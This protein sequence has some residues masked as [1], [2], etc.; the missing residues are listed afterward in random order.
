MPNPKKPFV[1]QAFIKP[2]TIES[3]TFQVRLANSVLKGGNSLVVAPTALGKTIV[4]ALV[5][6]NIL[7]KKPGKKILFLAPTKPLCEQH[8][9]TMKKLMKL[10]PESIVMLTGSIV[11]KKRAEQWN[12]A[13]IVVATPQTIGN[14]A[15][16]ARI[17][18][19]NVSLIVFD[20]AHRAVG[21]YAYVYI[22]KKFM[23]KNPKGLVLGLTA[24]P[25]GREEHIKEV[26]KNLGTK[27]I[28][29]KALEDEDVLQYSH[30]INVEW[31][32]VELPPEFKK[33]RALIEHFME[34]KA[35]LIHKF[36]LSK[37]S[38]LKAFGKARLITMQNTVRRRIASSGGK[39]PSLFSAASAIASM[40]KASHAHTLLETQGVNALHS[41]L[42]REKNKKGKVSRATS[43]FLAN[44]GIV[45]AAELASKLS[46]KGIIHPKFEVLAKILQQQFELKPESSAIVFNHY[47]DSIKRLTQELNKI[48]G[49]R[50]ERFVGQASKGEEKGMTQKEQAE[51]IEELKDGKLNCLVASSVH[52]EEFIIV[53]NNVENRL[54]IKKIGEFV[55][56]FVPSKTSK[57]KI[58]KIKGYS[59]LS[60]NGTKTDFLPITH[61]HKHLR[62]S[63]AVET[64]FAS[65]FR[66]KI[67]EDHSLFTFDGNSKLVPSQPKQNMFAKVCLSAPNIEK[68]ET[69]DLAKQLYRKLPTTNRK[70]VYCTISGLNQP[71]IRILSSNRKFLESISKKTLNMETTS[72]KAHLDRKTVIVVRN[73]LEA[74]SFISTK[75]SG[76]N[77]LVSITQ[78]GK[79]YLA[80]LEWLFENTRYYKGKYRLSL[81]SVAES[82]LDLKK[83][84]DI[85]IEASYGKIKLPRFLEVKPALAEMLGLYV[86]EGSA[87]NTSRTAGIHLAARKKEMQKRMAISVREGLGIKPSMTWRGVDIHS[88]LAHYLIKYVFR[89]GIGAYN[90]EV[91][92][93]VFTLPTEHK[94]KFLEG[95]TRG[96]GHI[97]E[98]RIVLT[99]VSKKLVTGL[100]F[101]LRQLGIK[102][103]TLQKSAHRSTFDV[104][105][106]ESV[107]FQKI[108]VKG[109][110]CYYDL[111]PIAYSNKRKFAEAK[112]IFCSANNGQK[113]RKISKL[114]EPTCFDYIKKITPIKKQPKFVYDLSVKKT[115]LFVGG[116]GLI[117]LHNSVAEEGLD[118]PSVD[119]VVFYEPVPSEIRLIQRRGR[120]GRLAA[121]KAVILMARNTRDEVYY[122]TSV[123]KEKKMH[124]IL[125]KMKGQT[126]EETYKKKRQEKQTT[127]HSFQDQSDKIVVYVDTR[128][129]ES[130]V[131]SQ[132]KEMGCSVVEKQLG[133]GDYVPGKE[134]AVERKTVSD[135]LSSIVDGR[136]GKQLINMTESYERPL[137]IVEGDK[138]EL[139]ESRNIHKNAIIGMLT[140]IALNYG[141]PILFTENA[142]ETADY[143]YVIAKREQLGKGSDV[144]LRIG[145]KG[146]SL[147]EQQR[148]LVE[149]LPLVG[150][151]MS[152]K[153]LQKFGSVKGIVNAKSKELQEIENMG[154]KKAKLI[155]QVLLKEYEGE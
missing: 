63:K 99:T 78:K 114:T 138:E 13:K 26:C 137:V 133:V 7:E 102:K 132:L 21:E 39:N 112:N 119:L 17:S 73:R 79:K 120:T 116:Q 92:A 52:P 110:K 72:E 40:M 54:E 105:I 15:R 91:P 85:F 100:I 107:P 109:N 75:N 127:L 67:T 96:D 47:R 124:K 8:Q 64:V 61:V 5:M 139:F 56:S 9:K 129:K 12:N 153:L 65:G 136:L 87:R 66:T 69:L 44:M 142:K 83:F 45:Q 140:S 37:S 101:L 33:I 31:K 103:I 118:I 25:G 1:K 152:K 29:I 3:R 147:E 22:A 53:Q 131:A 27:N 84:C 97:T 42:E 141:M 58:A 155:R 11:Y 93:I 49:L 111:V 23:K 16:H 4:A 106:M 55:D 36:G 6:A 123:N 126:K 41:Y 18:L 2:K 30:K 122:W 50:V 98:K 82:E 57:S 144:R 14:D 71:K 151:Q 46:E 95:Y 43:Q 88:K 28:E 121:G 74:E 10:E 35:E 86:A 68:P 62:K 70:K 20:E 150:P 24:S 117:C 113:T 135:F 108:E 145:K 48:P 89:A 94:W 80:F 125:H 51:K 115:Q 104:H 146:L 154:Q 34:K 90:K 77:T 128:E 38:S 130:G 81:Q 149:S 60:F 143:I 59:A 134:I 148:F 32:L 76:R 19:K